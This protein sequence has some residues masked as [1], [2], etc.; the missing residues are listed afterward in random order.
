MI[1]YNPFMV[2]CDNVLEDAEPVM[3]AFGVL[4]LALG[5]ICVFK[6]CWQPANA[7]TNTFAFL[8]VIATLFIFIVNF[9]GYLFGETFDV[10][11]ASRM[12]QVINL[13]LLTLSVGGMFACIWSSTDIRP[14]LFYFTTCFI[15]SVGG[16]SL[17]IT[18][19]E[20]DEWPIYVIFVLDWLWAILMIKVSHKF[21]KAGPYGWAIQKVYFSD[22]TGAVASTYAFC[23]ETLINRRIEHENRRVTGEEVER[24]LRH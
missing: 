10:H 4:V 15:G 12:G 5:F 24:I 16:F 1:A 7:C 22:V 20:I 14:G 11:H 6:C 9:F 2:Y 21:T 19:G 8:L 3:A 13:N 18:Y 17:Y 23:E